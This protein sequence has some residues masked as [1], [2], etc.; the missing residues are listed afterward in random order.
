M[1][2]FDYIKLKYMMHNI[3]RQGLRIREIR[4]WE[5]AFFNFLC[6]VARKGNDYKNGWKIIEGFAKSNI[7]VIKRKRDFL[8]SK[9]RLLFV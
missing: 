7:K 4:R 1:I 5:K 3:R 9:E 8:D 2:V 6:H